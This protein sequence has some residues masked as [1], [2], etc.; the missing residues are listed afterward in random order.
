MDL[1][2]AAGIAAVKRGV[3]PSESCVKKR[4]WSRKK[5]ME[6]VMHRGLDGYV[7]P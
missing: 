2:K 7:N 4:E 3:G 6:M 5:A 1:Q